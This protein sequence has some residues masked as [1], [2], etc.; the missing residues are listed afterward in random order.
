MAVPGDGRLSCVVRD[1]STK[2]RTSAATS[3]AVTS[4]VQFPVACQPLHS[5]WNR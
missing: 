3:N 1:A 2:A 5:S 4:F